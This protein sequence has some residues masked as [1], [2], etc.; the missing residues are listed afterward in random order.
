MEK[1][2]LHLLKV[3]KSTEPSNC[4]QWIFIIKEQVIHVGN[5]MSGIEDYTQGFIHGL[6]AANFKVTLNVMEIKNDKA[7]KLV[8]QGE[9][10]LKYLETLC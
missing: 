9:I 3:D 8:S 4:E 5:W 10:D 1:V 7:Y 6:E 2:T